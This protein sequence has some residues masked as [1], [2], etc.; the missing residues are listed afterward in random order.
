M[1][2]IN[3]AEKLAL[4]DDHWS[5]QTVTAVNDYDVKLV[6]VQ[7]EFVRHQHDDTDELFLVIDGELIIRFDEGEVLLRTGEMY[8]VPR[9]VYHCPVSKGE[10][11]I[12]LFERRGTVNTG[13]AGGDLTAPPSEI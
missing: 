8:V 13:D 7:G 1:H 10:T 12:M 6:K 4:I 5:P 3:L 9:G 2:S 11:S